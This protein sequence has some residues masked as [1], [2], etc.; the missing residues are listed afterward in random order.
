MLRSYNLDITK[1]N[2]KLMIILFTKKFDYIINY[3]SKY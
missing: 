1:F 3:V 2:K